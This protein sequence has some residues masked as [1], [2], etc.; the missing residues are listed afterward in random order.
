MVDQ[1]EVLSPWAEADL[2]PQ[3]GLSPRVRDLA[4]KKIG[5]FV[6]G[7]IAANPIQNV[8][9]NNLKEQFPTSEI[10]RFLHIPNL[11][12]VETENKARY[13]DWLKGI[14]TLIAA[15]GD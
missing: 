11:S 10:T 2:I 9:E 1:Y 5:L 14:D 6:N 15:V 7:K 8:I 13:E 4:G 12:V 3:R